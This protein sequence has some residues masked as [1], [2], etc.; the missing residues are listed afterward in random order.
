MWVIYRV[1]RDTTNL[2]SVT[3]PTATSRFTDLDVS[4]L[5]VADLT[6]GRAAVEVNHTNLA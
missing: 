2:R 3:Q 1:H 5:S 6:D 4:V